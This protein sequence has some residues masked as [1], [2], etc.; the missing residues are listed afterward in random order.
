[1]IAT[2]WCQ[3]KAIE[4]ICFKRHKNFL[5]SQFH[6]DLVV[7]IKNYTEY[8]K[9]CIE[10]TD[11]RQKGTIQSNRVAILREILVSKYTLLRTI[12]T[13]HNMW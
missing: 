13:H 9:F 6:S 5:R 11:G 3:W 1:M 7:Q 8:V 4:V 10:E 12:F 2:A